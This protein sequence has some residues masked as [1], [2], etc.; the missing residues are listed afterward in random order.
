[1]MFRTKKWWMVTL[2][3]IFLA[4]A[5]VSEAAAAP[6]V[7]V[8]TG[9]MAGLVG[10]ELGIP[11]FENSKLLFVGG[12]LG[13]GICA[14]I[15][16]HYYFLTDNWRPFIGGYLGVGVASD[17]YYGTYAAFISLVTGGVEYVGDSGF[18]FT[19]EFGVAVAGGYFAPALGLSFGRQ[20]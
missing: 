5:Q 1:M 6:S 11:T 16:S 8:K 14:G 10:V 15:G 9:A 12:L 4:L 13:N 18:L 2:L 19:A 17:P 7:A 20:F 3:V